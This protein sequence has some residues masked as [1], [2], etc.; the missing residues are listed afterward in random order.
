VRVLID[1]EVL[2]PEYHWDPRGYRRG[3]EEFY[4]ETAAALL[5]LGFT[6]VVVRYDGPLLEHNGVAYIPRSGVEVGVAPDAY[7]ACNQGSGTI[8]HP[9]AADRNVYWT[10]KYGLRAADVQP[11][12]DATV[13]ISEYHR[14]I[15]MAGC[16]FAD[17][18]QVIGHGT[19]LV[20][21]RRPK[22]PICIYTSAPD[23]GLSFLRE[24]WPEVERMTGYKL[25]VADGSMT[26]EEMSE[27]YQSA[28]YWLH[29]GLGIELF[30][31][32]ALK[33]QA[34]HCI[35]VVVPHMALD[36]TVKFGVKA[37]LWQYRDA[38]IAA[39]GNPLVVPADYKA[40]T[41]LEATAPLAALL[42]G[43]K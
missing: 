14:S 4:V 27:L 40:P 11:G 39:L 37:S 21:D 43:D 28:Q 23:R 42:R 30:C 31:I 1:T 6:E 20:Y 12:W 29:P 13:V 38:L 7:L 22:A 32:S 25:V 16:P 10:N 33:A 36:E 8:P 15:F 26:N 18:P 9:A 24:I 17:E 34:A 41:W 5:K 2:P 3:T 35:P 19:D